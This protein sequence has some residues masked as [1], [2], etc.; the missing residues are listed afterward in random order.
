MHR[1]VYILE[2]LGTCTESDREVEVCASAEG[3]HDANRG[4]LVVSLDCFV[5][6]VGLTEKETHRH[7]D[8]LPTPERL[9]EG[10]PEEDASAMVHDIF[11]GWAARVRAA[12]A[13]EHA[14]RIGT[15]PG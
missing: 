6:P 7:P 10:V 8:W 11:H 5:R 13:A 1:P 15:V 4:K 14:R 3:Q 12:L 9:E 2:A